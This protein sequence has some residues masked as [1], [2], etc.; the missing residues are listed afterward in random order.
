MAPNDCPRMAMLFERT[1]ARCASKPRLRNYLAASRDLAALGVRWE[2]GPHRDFRGRGRRTHLAQDHVAFLRKHFSP[3]AIQRVDLAVLADEAIA[4]MHGNHS[5]ERLSSLGLVEIAR[6]VGGRA[7]L[8]LSG[9][10]RER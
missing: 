1:S 10:R 6:D 3:R 5:W 7:T 4:T 9:R 8:Q 2:A